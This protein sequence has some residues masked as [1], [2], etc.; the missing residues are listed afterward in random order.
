MVM[1]TRR[2][3]LTVRATMG[4]ALVFTSFG[5]LLAVTPVWDSMTVAA[6]AG[7]IAILLAVV[8]STLML[9]RPTSRVYRAFLFVGVVSLI[10][11]LSYAWRYTLDGGGLA[12]VALCLG[13]AIWDTVGACLLL[14]TS[15]H[16]T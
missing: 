4:L 8:L 3:F 9:L 13:S 5:C 6:A 11:I 14:R 2:K 1:W 16:A 15:G 7:A 12:V 10:G